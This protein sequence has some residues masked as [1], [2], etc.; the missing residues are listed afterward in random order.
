MS[1]WWSADPISGGATAQSSLA[2]AHRDMAIR[3]IYGEAAN[4]PDEGQ[5]AVASVIKNR[6]QAGRYGGD[7]VPGVVL[8]KNQF[9]PWGNNDARARMMALKQDDPRYQ[10]IGGIVDQVFGGQ[11][12]DPTNGATHFVAPQAQAAL[13]RQMPS[14]A[15][16]DGQAIGR[17]TFFA[18]EGRVQGTNW[19]AN[20]PVA[21]QDLQQPAPVGANTEGLSN[22]V[23]REGMSPPAPPPKTFGEK[24]SDLWAN[25]PEGGLTSMVKPIVKGAQTMMQAGHG[26]IPML[27]P[28]GHTNPAVIQGAF[29][30]AKGIPMASAPGGVFA[31]QVGK[32]LPVAQVAAQRVV[33]S[34]QELKTAGAEALQSPAIKNL[35]IKPQAISDFAQKTKAAL[36][37]AGLDDTL[38]AGTHKILDK[39]AK[40]PN[41]EGATAI[42]TGQNISTLRKTFSNAA[43]EKQLNGEPTQNAAAATQAMKSLDELVPNIKPADVIGGDLGAAVAKWNEGRANYSAGM[44]AASIDREAIRAELRAA[45]TNSGQN[46]SNT[47]RQRMATLMNKPGGLNGFTPSE[48]SMI[49]EI[50]RGSGAQNAVRTVGNALGGGLGVGGTAL[51]LGGFMTAGPAGAAIPFAGYALKSLSNRM[52]LTQAAKLSEAIRSR[53]PLANAMNDFGAKAAEFSKAQTPRAVAAVNIA[54]RNLSNNLR[55]AGITMSPGDLLRSLSGSMKSAADNEQPN[56]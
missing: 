19:W 26:D 35:E 56:P 50:V 8:A 21:G 10:K 43:K 44:H 39:L 27:G 47:I 17:H 22:R 46:V 7:S 14:W 28:D 18:P 23:A 11:M 3:T 31:A 51:G 16:G 41:E 53:A 13:G 36:D 20:D 48:R 49:E 38:A 52:T 9:E 32:G 55:D 40:A 30:V 4:E 12:E 29:D 15:Q 54:A 45:A 25:P 5:A 42:I 34:V 37:E 1:D 33:P 2:P 24:L 6:M